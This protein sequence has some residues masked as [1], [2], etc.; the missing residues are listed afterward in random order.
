MGLFNKENESSDKLQAL[1]HAIFHSHRGVYKRIDE[2][3]ELLELLYKESSELLNKYPWVRGW[4]KSQDEFL[5][6]LAK[7]SGAENT[8]RRVNENKPYPR[9]FPQKPEI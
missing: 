3:R 8:L 2:N 6:G 5:N 9:P 1:E 7:L 4:I